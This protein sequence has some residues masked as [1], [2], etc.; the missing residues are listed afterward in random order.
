[1]REVLG[2]TTTTFVSSNNSNSRSSSSS[3]GNGNGNGYATTT[4]TTAADCGD[5]EHVIMKETTT[6]ER[7]IGLLDG[8]YISPP[9][10]SNTNNKSKYSSNTNTSSN[11]NNSSVVATTTTTRDKTPSKGIEIVKVKCSSSSYDHLLA[12]VATL[13]TTN[14]GTREHSMTRGDTTNKGDDSMNHMGDIMNQDGDSTTKIDGFV[15]HLSTSEQVKNAK[16]LESFSGDLLELSRRSAKEREGEGEGEEVRTADWL[17]KADN[18]QLEVVFNAVADRQIQQF[19]LT[20][21]DP[22]YR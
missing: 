17:S 10:A 3:N 16:T 1:M 8:S 15:S 11:T 20:A 6:M 12:K 2:G 4:T 18:R 9:S 19:S 5:E 13:T 21:Q 14:G 7:E 22:A